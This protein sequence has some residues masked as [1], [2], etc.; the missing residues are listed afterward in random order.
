MKFT[1]GLA[2]LFVIFVLFLG[3]FGAAAL[4]LSPGAKASAAPNAVANTNTATAFEI[5]RA[6]V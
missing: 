5:G 6:H 4:A 2:T 3:G 1:K